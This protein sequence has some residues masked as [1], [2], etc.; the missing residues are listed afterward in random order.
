MSSAG[1]RTCTRGVTDRR[2]KDGQTCQD[3]LEGRLDVGGVQS[4]RLQKRQT[5]L[6]C[7]AKSN[8]ELTVFQMCSIPQIADQSDPLAQICDGD[9]RA[10]H[11]YNLHSQHS[12][13]SVQD[14]DKAS[15][16]T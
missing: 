6:L 9:T 7:G 8:N 1:G 16:F 14:D 12:A 3:G 13:Q 10:R 4:R 5:I 2:V 11:S 15:G